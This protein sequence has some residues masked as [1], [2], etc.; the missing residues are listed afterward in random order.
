M[1]CAQGVNFS[2]L[3]RGTMSPSPTVPMGPRP[4]ILHIRLISISV[5][6]LPLDSDKLWLPMDALPVTAGLPH[7]QTSVPG[8]RGL[9]AREG[10]ALGFARSG[11]QNH[12]CGCPGICLEGF[13]TR[14]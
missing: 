13:L 1:P 11:H 7:A 2:T 5:P 6:V 4:R 3:S 14:D 10:R 8:R 9:H 12:D